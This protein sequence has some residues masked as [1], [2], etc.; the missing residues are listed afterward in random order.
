[1]T[2]QETKEAVQP[3]PTHDSEAVPQKLEANDDEEVFRDTQDGVAFRT[4]GWFRASVMFLKV[5]IAQH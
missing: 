5:M 4:V 2:T 3:C 1:M